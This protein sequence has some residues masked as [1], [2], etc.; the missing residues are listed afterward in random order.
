[1]DFILNIILKTNIELRAGRDIVL[2][3]YYYIS[4]KFGDITG[5]ISLLFKLSN[6]KVGNELLVAISEDLDN[7][8][9]ESIPGIK[10]LASIVLSIQVD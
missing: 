3:E 9:F 7:S 1:M 6:L 8:F 10:Q 5:N 2:L 4:L